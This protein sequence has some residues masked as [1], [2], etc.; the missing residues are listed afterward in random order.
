MNKNEQ[1]IIGVD[2]GTQGTK[3]ALY[4]ISGEQL[5]SDFVSSV[6]IT[7]CVGAVEED[8]DNILASVIKTVRAVMEKS[9]AS[10]SEEA[11]ARSIWT[12]PPPRAATRW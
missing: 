7:P 1:L 10:P 12:P 5:A 8:P 2:I 11:R 3:T 4:S 9:G 6:L